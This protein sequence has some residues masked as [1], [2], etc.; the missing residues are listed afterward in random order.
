MSAT[1]KKKKE[2]FLKEH[3]RTE[4]NK[5]KSPTKAVKNKTNET[6]GRP[7]SLSPVHAWQILDLPDWSTGQELLL[8]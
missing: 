1:K 6:Q 5:Q 7:Y 4:T 8:L 2:T 3:K